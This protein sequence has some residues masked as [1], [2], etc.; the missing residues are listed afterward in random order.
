VK[1]FEVWKR[2]LWVNYRRKPHFKLIGSSPFDSR[3]WTSK[4][5]DH[6][7]SEQPL[8]AASL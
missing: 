2:L 4:A 6:M 3:L 5:V 8:K 7:L 1:I